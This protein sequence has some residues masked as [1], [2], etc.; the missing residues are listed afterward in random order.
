MLIEEDD[1]KGACIK[2]TPDEKVTALNMFIALGKSFAQHVKTMMQ[3]VAD[4]HKCDGPAPLYHLLWHNT[5]TAES[6]IRTSQDLLTALPNKLDMLG[7]DIA[8]FCNNNTK[9][10]KTLT[11]TG[12]TDNIT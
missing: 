2:H 5:G 6:V 4:K 11:D 7:F 9:T 8:K 3:T 1:L 10:L 12:D